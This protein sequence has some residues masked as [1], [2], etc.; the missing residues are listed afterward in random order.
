M[1]RIVD[2]IRQAVPATRPRP[3]A[4]SAV[5][6][7]V[8]AAL[9]FASLTAVGLLVSRVLTP[10]PLSRL[11][12]RVIDW[13][14]SERT[15]TLNTLTRI[16]TDFATTLYVFALTAVIAVVLRVWL[17][18][19]REAVVL[20]LCVLGEWVLFR[21]VNGTVDR[22]RPTPRLDGGVSTASFPSGHAGI[23]VAFY[24]GLA[25]ILLRSLRLRKTAVALASVFLAIVL[26][27]AVTRLYRGMHYPTDVLGAW[28]L[29]GIWI[30]GV[31]AVLL[32]REKGRGVRP[33]PSEEL[34]AA[35]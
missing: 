31:V 23:A 24:G 2:E 29:S 11:D 4:S 10:S 32:P 30:A 19:W 12:E 20:V 16:G 27:V 25:L 28:F 33:R 8:L 18:R 14:A 5:L 17:G 13:L 3:T 26:M 9:L 22:P 1:G 35:A 21:L 34:D 6:L 15:P 7:V